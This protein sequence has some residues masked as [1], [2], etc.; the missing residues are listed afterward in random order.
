MSPLQIGILVVG[1]VILL[2][3]LKSHGGISG[4][5]GTSG[6]GTNETY[7]LPKDQLKGIGVSITAKRCDDSSSGKSKS[8]VLA[9]LNVDG[10]TKTSDGSNVKGL[11]ASVRLFVQTGTS[12]AYHQVRLSD[13]PNDSGVSIKGP[14]VAYATSKRWNTPSKSSQVRFRMVLKTDKD[15]GAPSTSECIFQIPSENPPVCV[16]RTS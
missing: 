15:R 7:R 8:Y 9:I 16:V 2:V 11:N 10:N 3:F 4:I 14:S 5:T 6:C 12:K 13:T 1:A